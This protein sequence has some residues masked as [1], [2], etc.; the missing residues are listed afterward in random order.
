[1]GP[2]YVLGYKCSTPNVFDIR[3][4]TGMRCTTGAGVTRGRMLEILGVK[5]I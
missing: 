3:G 1:M 4:V 2:H 5:H